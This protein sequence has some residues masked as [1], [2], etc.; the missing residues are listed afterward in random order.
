MYTNTHGCGV[1]LSCALQPDDHTHALLVHSIQRQRRT[2]GDLGRHQH[3]PA[4]DTYDIA[5][6]R[7]IQDHQLI[8]LAPK[9]REKGAQE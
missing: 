9:A 8:Q 6:V 7:S 2:G 1:G 4:S 5:H 3:L